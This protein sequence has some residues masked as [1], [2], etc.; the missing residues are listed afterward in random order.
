MT[1][2]SNP[3]RI[4]AQPINQTC[5]CAVI[6]QS[7]PYFFATNQSNPFRDPAIPSI[8]SAQSFNQVNAVFQKSSLYTCSNKQLNLC[9][10]LTSLSIFLSKSSVKYLPPAILRYTV[11]FQT[12]STSYSSNPICAPVESINQTTIMFKKS[13]LYYFAIHLT[14]L[15]CSNYLIRTPPEHVHSTSHMFQQ[16]YK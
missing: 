1:R 3:V 6:K 9:H 13:C 11:S 15:P 8:L 10:V 7:C 2:S 12:S 5:A 14:N 4:P 16:S